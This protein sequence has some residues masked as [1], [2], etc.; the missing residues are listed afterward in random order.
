MSVSALK[1]PQRNTEDFTEA[2]RETSEYLC[3]PLWL[4][5]SARLD[6]RVTRSSVNAAR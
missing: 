4:I 1:K 2:H 6:W 5:P 3:V